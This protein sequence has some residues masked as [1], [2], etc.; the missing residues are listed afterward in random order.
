MSEASIRD[1]V[2]ERFPALSPQLKRAAQFVL[3]YPDEIATRSL[4]HV[5]REAALPP[6]TFSR[7]ARAMGYESYDALRELCRGEIRKRK[8]RFADKALALLEPEGGRASAQQNPFA[9]RQA[10]AAISNIQALLETIDV[11]ALELAARKLARARK[12][13]V[14]GSLSA[15]AFVDY[16]SYIAAMALPNWRVAG[17]SGSSLASA[18]VELGKRDAVLVM[19]HEPYSARSVRAASFAREQEAHVVAITDGAKSPVAA[20]A[21]TLFL[22]STDSPQF[23]PSHVAAL[24]LLESLMGMVVR[25]KG[26]A[27]QQR[28]A[29]VEQE[30]YVLG[31]YWQD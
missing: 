18:V 24:V 25:E 15:Y 1:Q 26:A 20:I 14:I 27:A 21:N 9:V 12:V 22:V 29:A 8:S 19:T 10:A 5:A 11:Q 7:L 4:R 31:E 28:I 16:V 23:F 6:P 2:V 30:N 17:R 13:V 3:D